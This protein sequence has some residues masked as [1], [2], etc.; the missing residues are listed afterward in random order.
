M[1]QRV[2]IQIAQRVGNGTLYDLPR[3]AE[4]AIK[5]IHSN[6][7]WT[8]LILQGFLTVNLL[9]VVQ[10]MR[11]IYR[12]LS[13]RRFCPRRFRGHSLLCIQFAA[14]GWIWKT[15]TL[16]QSQDVMRNLSNNPQILTVFEINLVWPVSV[17]SISRQDRSEP[18]FWYP[19]D[20]CYGDLE[21]GLYNV[22]F[23][24]MNLHGLE[25]WVHWLEKSTARRHLKKYPSIW[26]GYVS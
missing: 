5:F 14:I 26:D 24:L 11:S 1:G 18:D 6:V 16:P 15:P 10:C 23:W 2:G 4:N 21:L 9:R 3:I 17:R 25:I 22:G 19:N 7:S 12:L 20:I 8:P 13:H